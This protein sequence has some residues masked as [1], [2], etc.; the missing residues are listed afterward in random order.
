[1]DAA[2]AVDELTYRSY[3]AN[4]LMEPDVRPERW[5]V[6]FPNVARLE[7]RFQ[8]EEAIAELPLPATGSDA[9]PF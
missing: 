8:A 2:K 5:G 6:I 4:R 9:I 7:Q 1:M 3:R